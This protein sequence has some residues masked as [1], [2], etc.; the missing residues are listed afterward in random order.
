MVETRVLLQPV[1]GTAFVSSPS[2][3]IFVQSAQP[4]STS[5]GRASAP[6]PFPEEAPTV[7]QRMQRLMQRMVPRRVPEESGEWV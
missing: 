3:S 5:G 6:S 7:R 1:N 4:A 2:H